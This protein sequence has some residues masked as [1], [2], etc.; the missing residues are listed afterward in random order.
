MCE[1]TIEVLRQW[2]LNGTLNAMI[3]RL[4]SRGILSDE[5]HLGV[6]AGMARGWDAACES[7]IR[8]HGYVGGKIGRVARF[9]ENSGNI[10]ALYDMDAVSAEEVNAY[11]EAAAGRNPPL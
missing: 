4:N 1:P 5:D 3:A 11:L 2:Q 7:F 9:F 6:S 10:H 8:G